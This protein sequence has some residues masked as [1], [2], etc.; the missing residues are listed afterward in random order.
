MYRQESNDGLTFLAGEVQLLELI[1]EGAPLPHILDG[2]C[3]ALNVQL[4]NVVSLVLLPDHAEHTSHAFEQSAAMFGLTTFSCTPILSTEGEFLGTLETYCCF[5]R[6][7]SS[8]ES[9][10]IERAA[11]LAALAIQSYNQDLNSKSCSMGWIDATG[12]PFH[13]TPSSSN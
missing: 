8:T 1:S 3:T 2:V 10:V 5:S 7:P 11:Q 6:K 12:R 4:G 9:E 13:E